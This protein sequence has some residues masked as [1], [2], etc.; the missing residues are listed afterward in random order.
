MVNVFFKIYDKMKT[1]NDE[2]LVRGGGGEWYGSPIGSVSPMQGSE[3]VYSPSKVTR[4]LSFYKS[5]L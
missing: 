2:L 1:D 5:S 4:I 3:L